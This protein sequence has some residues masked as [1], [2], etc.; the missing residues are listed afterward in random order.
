MKSE[1]NLS[2]TFHEEHNM[3][4]HAKFSAALLLVLACSTGLQ[5]P[6]KAE[7][8]LP[9]IFGNHMVLQQGKKINVWGWAD[10]GEKIEVSLG[11]KAGS[12][13]FIAVQKATANKAGKWT[14]S[15]D[16][17][18]LGTVCTL[19]VRGKNNTILLKDILI[20]EVWVCSGQSNMQWTVTRS[21]NSKEELAAA[22]YPKIR[23]FYVPRVPAG[24]PADDVKATWQLCSPKTIGGFS[25]V[26]YFFGRHIHKN[27]KVPVGLIHTSWGGTRIEPW[28]P[29]VG[30]ESVPETKS[31]LADV[32]AI[33]Q[34]YAKLA[35]IAKKRGMKPPRH[36]L[37]SNRR[38]TGLYN[39]MVHPLVPLS[40][41]GAIWYQG[42]ANRG[43]GLLYEKKMHALINGW[44]S[45]FKQGDFP[46]YYVQLAPYRYGGDAKLLAKIWEAQT[47]V[48]KMKNTGMAVTVDIGNP[49][50]IHP[51]NKQDV[52]KR[53]AL[54]ALVK[55]YNKKNLVYSGPL[56]RSKKIEGSKIR[57]SFDHVGGGLV[58]RDKKPL[59]WF[60][61]AGSDGKFVKATAMIE[62][63]DIVVSSSEVK[64]PEMVRFGWDQLAEPNLSNKAGLP[65]SPFRTDQ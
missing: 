6:V 51:T 64:K 52:G 11:G 7:V 21:N 30:F 63:E 33:N 14:V 24:T 56:Y 53:L 8:K 50:N 27:L 41:R 59:S 12:T 16:K 42:E 44:R 40:I 62:G 9:A 20:G 57:I 1:L 35:E 23:L 55:D 26:S 39:G 45:V 5:Q 29:P 19:H 58:S 61:I 46:F 10:S 65:A 13:A 48:L 28:T 3:I 34:T 32:I 22:N 54:W 36:P 2:S 17:V 18:I 37:A 60:E 25:A 47:N 43:D 49:R 15:F 4:R 38:P 31:I